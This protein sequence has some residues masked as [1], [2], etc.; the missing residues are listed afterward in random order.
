MHE[1]GYALKLIEHIEQA[2]KMADEGAVIRI[3]VKLGME[4]GIRPESLRAAFDWAKVDTI[5]ESAE[6]EIELIPVTIH[7][8]LCDKVY[9]TEEPL[10]ECPYCGALGGE[11]LSGDEFLI[12]HIEFEA[13]HAS[14]HESARG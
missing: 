12:D 13:S 11:L 14:V 1:V 9:V 4:K 5:A 7:C 8:T 2:A 10:T 6:L 3:S